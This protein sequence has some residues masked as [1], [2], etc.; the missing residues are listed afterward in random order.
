MDVRDFDPSWLRRQ[1]GM[2]MQ[3]PFLFSGTI[4]EN[5]AIGQPDVDMDHLMEV[6]KL[7]CV[8][9]F[10]SDMP[11]GYETKVGEQGVGLSG[12]QRQRI[13]IARALYHDPKILIFDEATNALDTE[14]EQAIQANLDLFLENRTAL[15]IAHRLSTV[16]DADV[17]VV[18]DKGHIVEVGNHEELMMQQGLYY[19]MC[20]Q[21]LQVV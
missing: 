13:A 19:H 7:A 12:G 17:I 15:I 4:T 8:H 11:L 21:Q 3:E 1:V 18:L 9:D 20:S 14:S 2:V 16:R 6:S 5:I 10:V